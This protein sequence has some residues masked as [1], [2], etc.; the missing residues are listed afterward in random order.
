MDLF[1]AIKERRSIRKYTDKPIDDTTMEKLLDAARWA[2]NA[3]NYNAWRFIVINSPVQTKQLLNFCPGLNDV[4]AAIVLICSKPKQKKLADKVR[5][6]YMADCAIASQNLVLAAYSEGIGSCV[7]HYLHMSKTRSFFPFPVTIKRYRTQNGAFPFAPSSWCITLWSEKGVIHLYQTGKTVSGIP[8]RHRLTH[9]VG[10]QPCCLVIPDFEN[11]LH[12]RNRYAYFVHGHMVDEPIPLYQ[13]R[14]G[15]VED[16]PC[17]QTD[18]CSTPF[19]VKDVSCSDEPRLAMPASRALKS[20]RPPHFLQVFKACV[21]SG[22]FFLKFK[23]ATLC[24]SFGHQCTPA[25]RIHR[26]YEL[27]Q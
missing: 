16:R 25:L 1:K 11:S 21:L 10:H 17:R 23:Q 12:F 5:L 6:M 18:L 26:F 8:I 4:P 22:K 15:F 7:V 20:I 27:N 24:V 13:R 9:L 2:P 3:G 19:A 14:A